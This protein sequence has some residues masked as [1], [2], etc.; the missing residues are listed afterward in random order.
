MPYVDLAFRLNGTTLPVDHGYSLLS[1][2][3]RIVP[4]VHSSKQIGI[5]PVRGVYSGEGKLHLAAYSRLV[6][7]VP[8]EEIGKYIKLAGAKLD[9]DGHQ[10]RIG[11]PEVRALMPVAS[12]RARLVTIKGF[13]EKASFLA[14]ARRQLETMGV[15]GQ[16]MLGQRR[17]FR[18]KDKQ[19]VGFEMAMT[20]LT[21][22]ESVTLQEKGIGGRRRMGCGIFVPTRQVSP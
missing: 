13:L 7:R 8:D 15:A 11:V 9:L 1:A 14:A 2:V 3:S 12:L 16:V 4:E 5:Q 17:T 22:E 19:V 21:A 6:L 10:L 18:V 20:G